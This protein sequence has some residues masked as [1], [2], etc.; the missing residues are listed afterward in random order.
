[1]LK[2]PFF[3]RFRV[4]LAT[5]LCAGTPCVV[6]RRAPL[7]L[8][9]DTAFNVA[10]YV[11]QSGALNDPKRVKAYRTLLRGTQGMAFLARDI[12]VGPRLATLPQPVREENTDAA[13]ETPAA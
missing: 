6:A 10:Q 7:A 5:K 13:K 4:W 1:M 11:V 8:L 12:L 9:H 2:L 3:T